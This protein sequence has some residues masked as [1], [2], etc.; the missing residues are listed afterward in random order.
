MRNMGVGYLY[1]AQAAEINTVKV[2]KVL[3]SYTVTFVGKDSNLY[4]PTLLVEHCI[5]CER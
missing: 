4:P 2:S 1:I 3:Q 5:M